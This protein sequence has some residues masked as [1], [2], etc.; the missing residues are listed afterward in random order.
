MSQ[1]EKKYTS[2]SLVILALALSGCSGSGFTPAPGASVSSS[3][4][5]SGNGGGSGLLGGSVDW[6]A[7]SSALAGALQLANSLASDFTLGSCSSGNPSTQSMSVNATQSDFTVTSMIGLSY[8]TSGCNLLSATQLTLSPNVNVAMTNGDTYNVTANAENNYNGQSIGGGLQVNYNASS[9]SGSV[10]ILGLN[11]VTT[12]SLATNISVSSTSPIAAT[13][14]LSAP[15]VSL[16]SDGAFQIDDN[17]DG[18]TLNMAAS[19]LVWGSSCGCPVGGGLTGNI[20]GALSAPVS[21]S[22]GSTC[23]SVTLTAMGISTTTS[24]PQCVL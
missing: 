17:T 15:Y 8:N 16:S 6:G 5:S 7:I 22:F 10:N 12:G 2:T 4:L 13:L 21:I 18:L 11:S 1:F 9:M 19:G 23:G 24:V 3:S 14:S 20:S